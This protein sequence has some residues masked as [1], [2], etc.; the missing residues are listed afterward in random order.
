MLFGTTAHPTSRRGAHWRPPLPGVLP[1]LEDDPG[2]LVGQCA[3]IVA[4]EAARGVGGGEEASAAL[5][6]AKRMMLEVSGGDMCSLI[7]MDG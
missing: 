7:G 1:P 3:R 5:A 4:Q 6:R 2:T